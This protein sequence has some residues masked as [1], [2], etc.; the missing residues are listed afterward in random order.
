MDRLSI[1][2]EG[3]HLELYK[4]VCLIVAFVVVLFIMLF[5]IRDLFADMKSQNISQMFRKR[6]NAKKVVKNKA[7]KKS[8]FKV[9]EGNNKKNKT[10]NRD[11]PKLVKVK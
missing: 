7:F 6:E 9:Y 1:C 4:L 10:S 8:K 11:R 2:M 5:I 3:D